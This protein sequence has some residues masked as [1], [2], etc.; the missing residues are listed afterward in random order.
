MGIGGWWMEELCFSLLWKVT[1]E[2]WLSASRCRAKLP[3]AQV[4]SQ[5]HWG[6]I[7]ICLLFNTTVEFRAHTTS[8]IL[9]RSVPAMEDTSLPKES[10]SWCRTPPA[11]TCRKGHNESRHRHPRVRMPFWTKWQTCEKLANSRAPSAAWASVLPYREEI[12]SVLMMRTS[13]IPQVYRNRWCNQ[14][15]VLTP[16]CRGNRLLANLCLVASVAYVQTFV[17]MRTLCLLLLPPVSY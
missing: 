15:Y 14:Q 4:V 17:K 8:I 12:V 1:A 13:S 5:F 9:A 2:V 7:G 6:S 11:A 3:N 16:P 10:T